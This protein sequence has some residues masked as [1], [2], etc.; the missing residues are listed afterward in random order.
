MTG[1]NVQTRSSVL[2]TL[3]SAKPPCLLAHL[4]RWIF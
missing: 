2:S 1:M 3:Y 4:L